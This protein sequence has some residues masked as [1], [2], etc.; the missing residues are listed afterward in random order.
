MTVSES[1]RSMVSRSR[2]HVLFVETFF[3]SPDSVFVARGDDLFPLGHWLPC[4]ARIIAADVAALRA[5][6]EVLGCRS[7]EISEARIMHG[8]SQAQRIIRDLLWLW[9]RL[10]ELPMR[11][12]VIVYVPMAATHTFFARHSSP[13]RSGSVLRLRFLEFSD[14]WDDFG[15]DAGGCCSFGAK[16]VSTS[17]TESSTSSPP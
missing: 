16:A 6:E 9:K 8:L 2:P 12:R 13:G 17:Q 15:V 1:A 14:S 11:T 7:R 3:D 5:C 10:G 4:N